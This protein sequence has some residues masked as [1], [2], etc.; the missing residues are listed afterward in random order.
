MIVVKVS[1]TS[2]AYQL[3]KHFPLL[4]P[5]VLIAFLKHGRT[6][7]QNKAKQNENRG[8]RGPGTG[9]LLCQAVKEILQANL[10]PNLLRLAECDERPMN[11]IK[12]FPR[13][14]SLTHGGR[15]VW[16]T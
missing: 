11:E 4:T 7:M 12:M 3:G 10:T 16:Q 9:P 8:L 15:K 2:S 5:S 13:I 6:A 14:S 1:G